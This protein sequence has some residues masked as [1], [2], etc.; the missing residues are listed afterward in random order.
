ME[1]IPYGKHTKEFRV[2]AVILVTEGGLSVL[3]ASKRLSLAPSTLSTWVKK[4]KAGEL[5]SVGKNHRQ[6]S[7]Q[8]L[9]LH[10]LKR[11]LAEVK[12]ERDILKKA[13]AYFAKGSL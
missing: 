11:E 6:L 12:M 9:E 5:E 3:E 1:K 7:D 13:T 8:E 4:N 10:K 2:E